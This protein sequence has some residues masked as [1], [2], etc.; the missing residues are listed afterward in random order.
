M[1]PWNFKGSRVKIKEKRE[2]N[3]KIKKLSIPTGGSMAT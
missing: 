1:L 2:K 3:K